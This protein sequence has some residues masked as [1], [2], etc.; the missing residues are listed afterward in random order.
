MIDKYQKIY[1]ENKE[2]Y[3]IESQ[4]LNSKKVIEHQNNEFENISK[5]ENTDQKLNQ[6][7]KKLKELKALLNNTV[8]EEINSAK[9]ND[10]Q[11]IKK[12]R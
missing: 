11:G 4:D 2:K 10:E 9:Q 8:L 3:D 1:E 12:I 5:I 7:I 6:D